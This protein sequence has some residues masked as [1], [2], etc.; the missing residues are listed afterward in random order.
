MGK[1]VINGLRSLFGLILLS[2]LAVTVAASIDQN[3]F[4]AVRNMWPN[5]WFRATLADAYF[6]FLTFFVWV[7]YKEVHLWRKVVWF[8]AFM[9]LGN[10]TIATYMLLELAKLREGDSVKTLLT[11]RNG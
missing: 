4:V 3:L 8:V 11:R 9:L 10:L 5:W 1:S 6:G 2:M 7:A